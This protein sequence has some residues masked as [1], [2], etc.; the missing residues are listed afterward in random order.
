VN[1]LYI[2]HY[3]VFG[4]DIFKLVIIKPI[5]NGDGIVHCSGGPSP[6]SR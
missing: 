4:S 1:N 5:V 3:V 2:L 6:L